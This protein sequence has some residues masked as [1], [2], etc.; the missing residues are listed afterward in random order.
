MMVATLRR[1]FS[2]GKT[3]SSQSREEGGHGV[4]SNRDIFLSSPS[5]HFQH[6]LVYIWMI[7]LGGEGSLD[8][9]TRII[10]SPSL[11][12]WLDDKALYDVNT[13]DGKQ[14]SFAQILLDI[15][16]QLL[17]VILRLYNA[18]TEVSSKNLNEIDFLFWVTK[19]TDALF[20]I[21]TPL[22]LITSNS[23]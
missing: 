10:S 8:D 14:A 4:A 12:H 1:S 22:A 20:Y 13:M 11:S 21:H 2:V 18:W 17:S 5:I 23:A 3:D 19:I 9:F 16:S 15:R 6:F 7:V